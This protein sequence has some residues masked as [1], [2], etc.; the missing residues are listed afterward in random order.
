MP[1]HRSDISRPHTRRPVHPT[2]RVLRTLDPAL[3]GRV[4]V[5]D[6]DN[7]DDEGSFLFS[8]QKSALLRCDRFGGLGRSLKIHR[9]SRNVSISFLEALY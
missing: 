4:V 6:D 2:R 9:H 1:S 8:A 5:V 7:K 3:A